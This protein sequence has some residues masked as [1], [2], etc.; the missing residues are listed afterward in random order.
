MVLIIG[1]LSAI[2]LPQYTKT[3]EKS[4]ASELALLTKSWVEAMKLYAL[5]NPPANTSG[6]YQY[7]SPDALSISFPNHSAGSIWTDE[8]ICYITSTSGALGQLSCS[9][10]D[11]SMVGGQPSP[12]NYKY[13]V[14][15][16]LKYSGEVEKS[17]S[18]LGGN[19]F[20]SVVKPVLGIE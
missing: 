3:V 19:S 17:C 7:V 18:D 14:S 10:A 2:A 5:E 20:C 11:V 9:R 13:T 15:Y 1:I 8:F 16:K 4:R 12:V 6:V